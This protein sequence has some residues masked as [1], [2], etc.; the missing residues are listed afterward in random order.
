VKKNRT[1]FENAMQ[2]LDTAF[3]RALQD[4]K[5][6]DKNQKQ[7][8]KKDKEQ[9]ISTPLRPEKTN[10]ANTKEAGSNQQLLEKQNFSESLDQATHRLEQRRQKKTPSQQA[11]F[12]QE[13]REPLSNYE[14]NK[15]LPENS[16]NNNID[17]LLQKIVQSRINNA[18]EDILEQKL[19]AMARAT[20]NQSS[21][22]GEG[23]FEE[24]FFMQTKRVLK[25]RNILLEKISQYSGVQFDFCVDLGEVKIKFRDLFSLQEGDILPVGANSKTNFPFLVNQKPVGSGR[26]I[27]SHST[28]GFQVDAFYQNL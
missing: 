22:Q 17:H 27:K 20:N 24:D 25:N 14:K 6:L 11:P 28:V 18:L 7:E 2:Q 10:I 5:K 12:P 9:I 23:N 21:N 8:A 15:E 3:D 19:K 1:R 26:L 4:E 16:R 13:K